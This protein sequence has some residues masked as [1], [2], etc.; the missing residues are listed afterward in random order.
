M[1]GFRIIGKM[2]EK[3][4]RGLVLALLYFYRYLL[5]PA[6]HALAPGSGCRFYPTCSDYALEAVQKHG[7]IRGIWLA[8]KRL[9]RCHPWGGQ[10]FDP[11]PDTCSCREHP[12][13]QHST[14]LAHSNEQIHPIK[15]E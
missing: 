7:P 3:L 11:V 15:G 2:L 12:D 5:S 4:A 10:G 1:S 13:Q 6:L 9:A 8:I 14:P